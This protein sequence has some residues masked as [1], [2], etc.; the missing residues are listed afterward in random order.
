MYSLFCAASAA[1]NKKFYDLDALVTC[2]SMVLFMH[3]GFASLE[4]GS[5]RSK[6]AT[7]ILM[8]NAADLCFGE[9]KAE[10]VAFPQTNKARFLLT[11]LRSHRQ[12]ILDHF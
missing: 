7:N 2:G 12:T 6:N 8:K 1:K 4:A 3:A 9:A 10:N 11:K 5:V